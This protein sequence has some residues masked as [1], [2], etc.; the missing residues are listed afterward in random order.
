MA[1]VNT[2]LIGQGVQYVRGFNN[3]NADRLVRTSVIESGI[4]DVS[5]MVSEV[6]NPTE[7]ELEGIPLDNILIQV[8]PRGQ[9]I[10]TETFKYESGDRLVLQALPA[11][12]TVDWFD[13]DDEEPNPLVID[14]TDPSLPLH[15]SQKDKVG[16]TVDY[17]SLS[18][19][20]KGSTTPIDSDVIAAIGKCNKS[21]FDLA[22]VT[23]PKGHIIFLAPT[24]SSYRTA[25]GITFRG[26]WNFSA[27]FH[28]YRSMEVGWR[29]MVRVV[30]NGVYYDLVYTHEPVTFPTIFDDAGHVA[31]S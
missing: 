23:W 24:I 3:P 2:I 4:V 21:S 6:S 26:T 25:S 16:R 12:S 9:A 31:F 28:T 30:D 11:T 29:K 1:I 27:T 7:T 20:F 10:K 14:S 5:T 8:R 19:P 15:P 22:G 17:F 18:F 13:I